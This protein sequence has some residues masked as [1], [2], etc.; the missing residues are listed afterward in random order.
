MKLQITN[1]LVAG[2]SLCLWATAQPASS[3]VQQ[4]FDALGRGEPTLTPPVLES[5][6]KA[7][8]PADLGDALPEMISELSSSDRGIVMQ[9][10]VGLIAVGL[11]Q[12]SADIVKPFLGTLYGLF[13]TSWVGLSLTLLDELRPTPPPET[14]AHVAAYLGRTDQ[15][16][17][18]QAGAAGFLLAHDPG[19][20]RTNQA[21]SSFAART[22]DRESRI[23]LLDEIALFLKGNNGGPA[24]L[25]ASL[26]DANPAV[27]SRAI[28]D[29]SRLGREVL[30]KYATE[31][32]AIAADQNEAPEVKASAE[33]ALGVWAGMPAPGTR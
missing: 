5:M 9:A 14:F 11:R 29:L 23:S 3:S 30:D 8:D 12:D 22:L 24:L 19:S 17:R 31:L 18:I 25:A 2:L 4:Y 6:I 33:Q 27:R 1:L 28:Y 20:L 7:A 32:R 15:D 21:V 16:T 10:G 26:H 13:D